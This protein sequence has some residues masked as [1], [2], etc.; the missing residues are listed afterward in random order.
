MRF[1]N[2][3]SLIKVLTRLCLSAAAFTVG[4]RLATAGSEYARWPVPGSYDIR[5][6]YCDYRDSYTRF[7][8]GIDIYGPG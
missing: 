1:A 4:P 7:H 3:H 5:G 2:S 6:M 8:K